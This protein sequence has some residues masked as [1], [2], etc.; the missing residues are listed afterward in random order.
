[1][2]SFTKKA[3]NKLNDEGLI[4][5]FSISVY[6]NNKKISFFEEFETK[7]KF[8]V[9][10]AGKP[11]IA[12]VIWKLHDIGKLKF[13][14]KISKFWPEFSKNNKDSIKIKDVLTHTSGVSKTTDLPD[15]DYTELNR[16]YRWL[17]NFQP[18]S[19]PGVRIAYHEVTYGWILGEI[20]ERITKKSF[21]EAFIE[22]VKIPLNLEDVEF[23][24]KN[25]NDLPEKIINHYS[26]K[27]PTIPTI[28]KLFAINKVPLIS[29]TC[30]SRSEDLA[31]FYNQIINNRD[32]ISKSTRDEIL[33]V[34]AK[35]LDYNDKMKYVKLG[36]GI[37]FD[38][39]IFF[40]KEI[41]STEST[42]GHTGMVSSIGWA[43]I[44]NNIA[45]SICNNLLLSSALNRY[46]LNVI[47][48]AIKKDL[49]TI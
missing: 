28:F 32:W 4:N 23:Y 3:L 19:K 11:I 15:S 45:V 24:T 10:S 36:L 14:D 8:F 43:S 27:L 13:D 20:I 41:D 26:S 18:E 47:S 21:E 42:F 2:E 48:T 34:H 1:M 22:L 31:K 33:K 17:E 9:F 37:R 25:L 12:A 5:N 39:D 46:R 40:E 7:K 35:G 29:G 16:I 38:S 44:K 49:N 6:K 30:I